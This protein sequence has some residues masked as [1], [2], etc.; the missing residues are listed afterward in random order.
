[1]ETITLPTSE[2][3]IRTIKFVD[4]KP[5]LKDLATKYSNI[6]ADPFNAKLT[7]IIN[8]LLYCKI[9]TKEELFNWGPEDLEKVRGMGYSKINLLYTLIGEQ[10]P[11]YVR[12]TTV[13]KKI[14]EVVLNHKRVNPVFD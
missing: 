3:Y 10:E 9:Y 1:M 7:S 6:K 14:K 4:D 12:E 5:L 8:T 13:V 11:F 2:K